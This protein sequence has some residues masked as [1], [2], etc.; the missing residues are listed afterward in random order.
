MHAGH[1]RDASSA[2]HTQSSHNV[3]S[4]HAC[5]SLLILDNAPKHVL[6]AHARMSALLWILLRL[7]RHAVSDMGCAHVMHGQPAEPAQPG[8][9]RRPHQHEDVAG[10]VVERT[11]AEG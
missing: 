11:M 8:Q 2:R 1:Q 3:G 6:H 5:G 10:Q 7:L 4:P 9:I